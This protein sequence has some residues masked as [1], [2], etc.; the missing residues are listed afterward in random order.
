MVRAASA[1]SRS[2]RSAVAVLLA[3]PS[4]TASSVAYMPKRTAGSGVPRRR[5]RFF[6]A[7]CTKGALALKPASAILGAPSL[8]APFLLARN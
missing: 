8:G 4:G 2:P 3:P 1:V 7:V 6:V 5:Q